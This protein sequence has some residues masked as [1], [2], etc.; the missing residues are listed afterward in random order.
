MNEAEA[1]PE[2]TR[3]AAAAAVRGKTGKKKPAAPT[4]VAVV[5]GQMAV[6]STPQG[7]QVQLLVAAQSTLDGPFCLGKCRRIENDG[8]EFLSSI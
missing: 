7:A 2:P 3:V 6:D 4:P 8:V 1:T 5:P